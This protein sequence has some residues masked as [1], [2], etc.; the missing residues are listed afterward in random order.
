MKQYRKEKERIADEVI[1]TLE[2]RFPGLTN[3]VEMRDVATPITYSRYTGNWQGTYQGWLATPKTPL[4]FLIKKTLPG[5]DNFYIAGHWTN[6]GG[7]LP[8]AVI[9]G[10]GAVQMMCKKDRKKFVAVKP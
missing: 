7:G 9:T 4:T 10:R 3:Q 6:A 5:L 2:K 8:T 1:A